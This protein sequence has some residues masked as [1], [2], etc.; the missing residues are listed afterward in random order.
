MELWHPPHLYYMAALEP[1][2]AIIANIGILSHNSVSAVPNLQPVVRSIADPSVNRRRATRMLNGRVV[3]DYVPLYWAHHTPMQFVILRDNVIAKED[4]VFVVCDS[5]KVAAISGV[6]SSDGNAAS[7]ESTFYEGLGAI[8]QIDWAIISSPNA[9]SK[10]YKWQKCAEVLVPD[11]LPQSCITYL[12]VVSEGAKAR[13][14]LAINAT[15][16]TLRIPAGTQQPPPIK[17]QP[18]LY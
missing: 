14:S 3:H 7:S 12:A 9:F 1:N 15:Q 11:R 6:L 10:K 16:Q 4:L 5:H 13:L 17:V 2:A 8:T 18:S